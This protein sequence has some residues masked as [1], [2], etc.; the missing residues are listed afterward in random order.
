MRREIAPGGGGGGGGAGGV[1]T[2]LQL[3]LEKIRGPYMEGPSEE[4]G[5]GS[6][7]SRE[8]QA[9]FLPVP[10]AHRASPYHRVPFC[11]DA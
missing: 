1:Q 2:R 5:G 7:Q 9:R 3:P 4:Q 6:W 8:P 10:R 11:S